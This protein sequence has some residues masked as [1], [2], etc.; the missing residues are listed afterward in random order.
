MYDERAREFAFGFYLRGVSRERA[1]PE[2]RKQYA[3]FSAATWDAWEKQY[4]WK[5]RRAAADE[6]RREFEQL[7]QETP[8]LMVMDL[9][10][11]RQ[12]VM[13]RIRTGDASPQLIFSLRDLSAQI[14][15]IGEK[16]LASKDPIR[17]RMDSVNAVVEGLLNELRS[18]EGVAE[19]LEEKASLVGR[20]VETVAQQHG[21]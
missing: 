1:L 17:M 16:F 6:R 3:G 11:A 13:K 14:T 2:I 18:I 12:A 4:D 7:M 10:E 9:E 15:E 21:L 8:R 5:A 20:A 19:A